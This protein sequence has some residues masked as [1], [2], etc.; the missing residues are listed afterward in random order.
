M[1]SGKIELSK[2]EASFFYL[3]VPDFSE[4]CAYL[5]YL[6]GDGVLYISLII[7]LTKRYVW[8]YWLIHKLHL[9]YHGLKQNTLPGI[10]QMYS[11]YFNRFWASRQT[12]HPPPSL[13]QQ[14]SFN[15]NFGVL[16]RCSIVNNI[17]G[18]GVF[19]KDQ[20][21]LYDMCML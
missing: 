21:L 18:G 7:L 19:Q 15:V 12:Q 8:A 6:L 1:N 5:Q 17:N 16:L 20:C 3:V 11:L 14:G 9:C 4:S 2:G 10:S 13:P